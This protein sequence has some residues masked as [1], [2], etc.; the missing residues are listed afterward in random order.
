[1]RKK[2]AEPTFAERQ[3]ALLR[4]KV[5]P[6]DPVELVIAKAREEADWFPEDG[7]TALLLYRLAAELEKRL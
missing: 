6:S 7:R 1:M 5:V 2:R 3:Q 4:E